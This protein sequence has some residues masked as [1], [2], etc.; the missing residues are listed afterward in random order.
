MNDKWLPVLLASVR[1]GDQ[2]VHSESAGS[3]A[4]SYSLAC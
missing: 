4:T 2:G 3:W 1:L